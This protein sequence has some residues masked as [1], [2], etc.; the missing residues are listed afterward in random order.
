MATAAKSVTFIEGIEI[1]LD[2]AVLYKDGALIDEAKAAG[3]T[4]GNVS[5]SVE[6]TRLSIAIRNVDGSKVL[7]KGQRC[8]VSYRTV[9]DKSA[10][11]SALVQAGASAKDAAYSI[12]NAA[13]L[14]SGGVALPGESSASFKPSI[15]VTA[16]KSAAV[17][18]QNGLETQPASF[19]VKA[20]TGEAARGG[21]TLTDQ[22]TSMYGCNDSATA[23][24]K[25]M[26]LSCEVADGGDG[27][28]AD[29]CFLMKNPCNA[30]A[31]SHEFWYH[32]TGCAKDGAIGNKCDDTRRRCI[33]ALRSLATATLQSYRMQLFRIRRSECTQS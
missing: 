26:M 7:G 22:I 31:R 20:G 24:Q 5:V 11:V 33:C 29:L 16:E 12:N 25:A 2:S 30:L 28:A 21:F 9:L 10:Y 15:P 8:D 17:T 6:G 14:S 4:D 27:A 1:S 23:A 18:P 32:S 13:S 3:W 19:T